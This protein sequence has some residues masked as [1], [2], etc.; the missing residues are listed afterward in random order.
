MK[1]LG[2]SIKTLLN[3]DYKYM[4]YLSSLYSNYSNSMIGYIF[5]LK[6]TNQ[7]KQEDVEIVYDYCSLGKEMTEKE[8]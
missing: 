4:F 3:K 8:F 5:Y 1:E 6:E 7:L 2:T